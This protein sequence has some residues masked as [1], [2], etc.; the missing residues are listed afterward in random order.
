MVNG[1]IEIQDMMLLCNTCKNL[2]H[3]KDLVCTNTEEQGPRFQK[4]NPYAEKS[5]GC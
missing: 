1:R 2:Y 5:E 3:E 4:E